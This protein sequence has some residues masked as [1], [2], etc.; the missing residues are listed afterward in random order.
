M[1]GPVQ[2]I[3]PGL[4]GFLQLKQQ[5]RNPAELLESLYPVLELTDWYLQAR[6]LDHSQAVGIASIAIGFGAAIQN[7]FAPTPITVPDGEMWWV[8]EYTVQS[9]NLAAAT[10]RCQLQCAMYTPLVGTVNA[11]LLGDPSPDITGNAVVR[12]NAA[13]ARHFFAPPGAGLGFAL[14]IQ[15]TAANIT[16]T[17]F[18]RFVRLPL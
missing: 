1:G 9:G 3:P 17:G 10:E 13:R 16:Y 8:E 11:Y 2:V 12:R 15:E 18:A 7:L 14:F 4:L 6:T 5:G